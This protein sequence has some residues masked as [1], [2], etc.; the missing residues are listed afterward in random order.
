VRIFHRCTRR[1]RFCSAL[2]LPGLLLL[3][4]GCAA[5]VEPIFF[6]S[7]PAPPRV[8]LLTSFYNEGSLRNN[9][10]LTFLLGD[11][12]SGSFSKAYGLAFHNGQLYI[13][14]SGKASQGLGIVD[15]EKHKIEYVQ[16]GLSKPINVSIDTDGTTY[17]CDLGEDQLPGIAVFDAGHHFIRRMTL[18]TASGFY[19][20]SSLIIGDE[21]LVAD[22]KN[23][24]IHVL[25]KQT[26]AQL[27]TFGADDQLGW[28]THLSPTPDGNILIT[29]TGAQTLRLYSADGQVRS[30]IG[31]PGDRAGTFARPKATAVD[32]DGNI[33]VVDVAFQNVQ[34]LNQEGKSLMYFGA[35]PGGQALTM[36]A[37]IAI[38]YDR[39][40]IFQPYAAPDFTLEYVIAV[41]SQGG[42]AN[43]SKITLYGFGK[44]AGYDYTIPEQSTEQ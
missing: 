37:G 21:L 15:F 18:D 4:A 6:P 34:I 26:G 27:K 11:E 31:Q 14:D 41:S 28:P 12:Y 25:D 24:L 13:A 40:D 43:S 39:M 3:L 35:A 32:H 16:T 9:A 20:T 30:R 5:K 10:M 19:P 8:Q 33:Y 36:P 42:I 38:T 1:L 44:A 17:V 7:P 23:N 22:P 2:L 29:E